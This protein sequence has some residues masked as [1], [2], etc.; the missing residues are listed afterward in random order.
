MIHRLLLIASLLAVPAFAGELEGVKV[1]DTLEVAGK[2]LKLNGQGLRVKVFFKVYVGSLY[3]ENPSKDGAAILSAD[4]VRRVEMTM[5]R[6]VTRAQLEDAIRDG[7]KA[8]AANYDAVKDRLEALLGKFA[9]AKKG[10]SV[11]VQ[12]V[13]GKGTTVELGAVKHTTEGKDFADALF[14]A[15]LG[16]KPADRNLQKGM[17]GVK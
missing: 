4:E 12:Y 5:L 8:N 2:T 6:D 13:P 15:W 3:V 14:S 16:K 1:P 17:L 7:V 11:I 9:N 10:E